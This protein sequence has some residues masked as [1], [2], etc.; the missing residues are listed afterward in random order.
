MVTMTEPPQSR[1]RFLALGNGVWLDEIHNEGAETVHD[2]PGGS[3]TFGKNKEYQR[4]PG[5]FGNEDD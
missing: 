2:V 4:S 3:V 5:V 1:I